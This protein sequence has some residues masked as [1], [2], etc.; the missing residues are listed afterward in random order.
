MSSTILV[1]GGAG[2]I[3][4]HTCKALWREGFKPV[5][6]DD[7]STGHRRFVRWGPFIQA[8]INDS[9]AVARAIVHYRVSA[10][11][12]F[13]AS[14]CV[15]ESVTEPEKYYLNNV[16][17]TLSLLRG[18]RAAGCDRLVFSS[19]CAVYGNARKVPIRE[20]APLAPVNPYGASKAMNEQVL[21]DYRRA[22]GLKPICLRYFNASGADPDGDLGELRSPETHLIPRAMMA[23][24]G[25][26]TDFAV[27]GSN[28]ETEDGTA[29]RDYI[30]V[31]DLAD[32]HV[33]ALRR[34][35][36]GHG[37]GIYNLGTGSGHSVRQ[38]LQ[39]IEA[40]TGE[41]LPHVRGARRRGDPPI[42][43]ADPSLARRE[44]GFNPLRSDLETIIESSWAW[45]MRAHPRQ[46]P[47]LFGQEA[48]AQSA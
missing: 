24:Q 43:I 37:G 39:K 7:L 1:I 30:H 44:L 22:Y 28:F 21:F 40:V 14:A 12:H 31:S 5:V 46:R 16:A 36:E 11:L 18:M 13:A 32:A 6:F 3:G 33:A 35:L 47:K 25:H 17:G 2:Y 8:N 38:I 10:V 15:G 9:Q 48:R 29:V 34:L 41:H 42:L 45:H 19:T 26:I 4:A 20:D 23:L 27:F